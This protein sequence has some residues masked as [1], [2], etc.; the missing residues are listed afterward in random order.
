MEFNCLYINAPWD[1]GAPSRASFPKSAKTAS[2]GKTE[3][4]TLWKNGINTVKVS[5]S[6]VLMR[7]RWDIA[8]LQPLPIPPPR[9]SSA[10]I[11][12]RWIP[13]NSCYSKCSPGTEKRNPRGDFCLQTF[14][15]CWNNVPAMDFCWVWKMP[16]TAAI[17]C[18]IPCF[19]VLR[20][21]PAGAERMIFFREYP[22]E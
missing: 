8:Q 6:P 14:P 2:R 11:S 9:F 3:Q 1:P 19:S 16:G 10:R 13:G 4:E 22:M 18:A 15:G 12:F 7:N 5:F 20:T 17:P 21:I